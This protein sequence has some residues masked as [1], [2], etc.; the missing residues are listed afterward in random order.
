VYLALCA[1]FSHEGCRGAAEC[2]GRPCCASSAQSPM[3]SGSHPS[4]VW[5]QDRPLPTAETARNLAEHF[6]ARR[7]EDHPADAWS[8]LCQARGIDATA[9]PQSE[10]TPGLTTRNHSSDSL[11][12]TP[13]TARRP[14]SWLPSQRRGGWRERGCTTGPLRHDRAAWM[15]TKRKAGFI[16]VKTGS[17]AGAGGLS[18]LMSSRRV[19]WAQLPR[20]TSNTVRPGTKGVNKAADPGQ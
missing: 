10:G 1:T 11:H 19:S 9:R 8:P 12:R 20:Q 14:S 16:V 4:E 5:T 2:V 7:P 18:A 17:I 13:P 6:A 3:D 15:R